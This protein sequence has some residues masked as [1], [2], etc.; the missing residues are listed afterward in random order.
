MVQAELMYSGFEGVWENND[1]LCFYI[2]EE[3]LNMSTLKEILVRYNLIESYT[4]RTVEN[5]NWNESW[6]KSFEPVCIDNL[7]LIRADFHPRQDVPYDLVVTPKMSFG[8]GHH[9]TTYMMVQFLLETE[10]ENKTVLDMGCG[11]GILAIL[12]E[13]SGASRIIAIDNDD[14]AIENARENVLNNN[15]TR[16]SVL[17][18]NATFKGTY[19]CIL[20]NINRNMNLELLPLY[21]KALNPGGCVMLSG[22]YTHDVPDIEITAH[23][24]GLII[25]QKKERNG[26][27]CLQLK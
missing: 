19:D 23:K 18:D 8:T 12:A 2:H 25:V 13:K 24:A 20:S 22:F 1:S 15:C 6:E 14:W 3:V 11:T 26:W 17:K 16:I 4:Y 10:L 27:A 5:V 21:A 7:C 9:E